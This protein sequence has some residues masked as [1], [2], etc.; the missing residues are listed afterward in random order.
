MKCIARSRAS[1]TSLDDPGSVLSLDVFALRAA[2]V[3]VPDVS[4]F[5]FAEVS[6]GKRILGTLKIHNASQ[7]LQRFTA[8]VL[9]PLSPFE[10][11]ST[12]RSID[13]DAERIVRVRFQP[14]K[15]GQYLD[16]L[17]VACGPTVLRLRMNA[18][19]ADATI[20]LD[21]DDATGILDMGDCVHGG[22]ITRQMTI[23]NTSAF[24]IRYN[25]C[26][27]SDATNHQDTPAQWSCLD[28]SQRIQLVDAEDQAHG[29]PAS[30]TCDPLT[31]APVQTLHDMG[32]MNVDGT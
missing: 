32:A 28:P 15:T 24:S 4:A 3:L 6:A 26:V 11:V 1:D 23:T 29:W 16:F 5:Q 31:G 9:D 25:M 12:K 13:A 2:A 19:C 8:T 22:K 30:V 20:K 17:E 27:S 18:V 21:P 7:K 14:Q 10:V